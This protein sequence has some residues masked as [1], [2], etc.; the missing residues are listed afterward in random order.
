MSLVD[1]VLIF[2]AVAFVLVVITKVM[3]V[4]MTFVRLTVKRI[5]SGPTK[6]KEVEVDDFA[7][8]FARKI[9]KP[10]L[11]ADGEIR[12]FVTD[13]S[14]R[15]KYLSDY[16]LDQSESSSEFRHTI[17]TKL[18]KNKKATEDMFNYIL[19]NYISKNKTTITDLITSYK[20][21]LQEPKTLLTDYDIPDYQD[22]SFI[23]EQNN[24]VSYNN[25]RRVER[26]LCG[27]LLKD[28]REEEG[29]PD[30]EVV[31]KLAFI[32]VLGLRQVE[33]KSYT[34]GYINEMLETMPFAQDLVLDLSHRYEDIMNLNELYI[35]Q[36]MRD[37]QVYK[38]YRRDVTKSRPYRDQSIVSGIV[39]PYRK[40]RE[41]EQKLCKDLLLKP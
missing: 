26:E 21:D 20:L 22:E 13:T 35:K 9:N 27:A 19:W 8:D 33:E 5:K 18:P 3:S 25:Y 39:M 1:Y 6:N 41:I 14:E 38:N 4:T 29:Q 24:I 30:F 11:V 28:I 32:D 10:E 7:G 12:S 17:K 23:E 40:F 31:V 34:Y 36:N 15:Y 37:Q 16:K 2:G